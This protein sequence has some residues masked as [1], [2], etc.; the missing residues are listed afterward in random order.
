[1]ST[2]RFDEFS[3]ALAT[4]TSR[5]NFFKVLAAALA[6][7][8]VRAPSAA[9]THND[10][11]RHFGDNCRSNAECCTGFCIRRHCTCPGSEP[12]EA[13][14]PA[15]EQ[16]I[17]CSGDEKPNLDDCVCE[18]PPT[19]PK[20]CP[21]NQC[22][23]ENTTCCGENCCA[24]G[25]TCCNAD[26]GLCCPTGT[27]CGSGG[28]AVCC[29]SNQVCCGGRCVVNTCPGDQVFNFTTCRCECP[30]ATPRS[31]P[32][33]QCCPS[34][35]TCCGNTCCA[36]GTT[37]CGSG[38]TATCCSSTGTR[39]CNGVC[40]PCLPGGSRRCPGETCTGGGQC[41]SGVCLP[42]GRCA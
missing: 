36:S 28:D 13:F 22:C 24:S 10:G 4:S 20:S 9:A 8:V 31:C 39:C 23:A 42:T 21:D 1:M 29:P 41:C 19:T 16:C 18:C 3:K 11:C 38:A 35:T 32:N 37:C 40:T 33:N 27:C 30:A 12:L 34:D 7:S 5:R 15:T 26:L 25:T 2:E 14:C 6:L 17:V